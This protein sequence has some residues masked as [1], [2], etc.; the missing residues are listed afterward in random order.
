MRKRWSALLLMVALLCSLTGCKGEV[1]SGE[2]EESAGTGYGVTQK[3]VLTLQDL[4]FLRPGTA[5]DEVSGALGSPL[6]YALTESDTDTYRLTDGETLVLTYNE[7][8]KITAAVF[9]DTS[10]KKQDFFSY[11]NSLGIL[12]NYHSA[13]ELEEEEEQTPEQEEP[14]EKPQTQPIINT[15][16]GYFSTKRYRYEMVEQLLKEGVERETVVSALGRPNSFSSVKFA[17]DSYIID[18]Y[19]MEDGSSLLL[20]YGYTRTA[21]RAVQKVKGSEVSTYLG[22]WGQAEK[23]DGFV[24]YTR[25][26]S[27]FNTLKKNTK[28]SEIYLRFGEPDWLEGS[29][30]RYRD[31][32]MLLNGGVLYLDFGADHAGLTAAVLQKS[33]GSV[34]NYTL[35]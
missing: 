25:N 7:N 3:S 12:K 10:G 13:G 20:D 9:T 26:Q 30:D 21:L 2:R 23:P 14:V 11:L 24:R 17:E 28:P 35:K 8:E 34:V 16:S 27:V 19:V 6:S 15:D 33:D 1:A 4:Y 22:T 29:A 5:R 18:V 32:Y 31:A